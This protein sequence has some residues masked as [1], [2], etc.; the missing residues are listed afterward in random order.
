MQ[1]DKKKT[2][3]LHN[4]LSAD[5]CGGLSDLVDVTVK[6]HTMAPLAPLY[7]IQTNSKS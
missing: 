5:R 3:Q 4:S 7:K 6:Q 1:R 2:A